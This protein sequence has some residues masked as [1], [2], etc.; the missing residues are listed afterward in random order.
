MYAVI[1]RYEGIAPEAV[2]EIMRSVNESL[3]PAM[4]GVPGFVAYYALEEGNGVIASIAV[5]Q[6]RGAADEGA[7][8]FADPARRSVARE[9][10]T[11][12]Q[13]TSGEVI[14]HARGATSGSPS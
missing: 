11:T 6:D 13:V 5:F 10:L 14:A 4:G 7:R 8:V 2:P 3:L 1:R 9:L 12:P